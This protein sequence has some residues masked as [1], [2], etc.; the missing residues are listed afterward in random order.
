MGAFRSNHTSSTKV[1]LPNLEMAQKTS[2]ID[3]RLWHLQI[4]HQH[5]N[6]KT[7]GSKFRPTDISGNGKDYQDWQMQHTKTYNLSL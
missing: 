1:S 5:C 4:Q 2:T 7:A 6:A 3:K